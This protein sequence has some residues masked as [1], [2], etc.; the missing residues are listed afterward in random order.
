MLTLPSAHLQALCENVCQRVHLNGAPP[1]LCQP[2]L[3]AL[4]GVPP[5]LTHLVTAGAQTQSVSTNRQHLRRAQ[6]QH[7]STAAGAQPNKHDSRT[8]IQVNSQKTCQ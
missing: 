6:Q 1:K 7:R 8:N 2:L 5:Q 4:K 3:I